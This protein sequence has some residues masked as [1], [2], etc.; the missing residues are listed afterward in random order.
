MV[1]VIAILGGLAVYG[2]LKF[3]SDSGASPKRTIR[4]EVV[5]V[6]ELPDWP[7]PAGTVLEDDD[8]TFTVFIHPVLSEA[9]LNEWYADNMPDGEPF[10]GWIWCETFDVT[11]DT[12]TRVFRKPE[13][14]EYLLVTTGPKDQ[15]SS[16][17]F[18]QTREFYY[19]YP[20]PDP[21]FDG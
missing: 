19:S 16:V 20:V 18:S 8:P 17:V 2:F 12:F 21:C 11:E 10:S 1:W 9:E 15:G 14:Q 13:T 5:E 7:V 4:S 3:E 6:D